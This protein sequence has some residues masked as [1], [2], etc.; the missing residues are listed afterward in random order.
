MKVA[1]VQMRGISWPW[2][3]PSHIMENSIQISI[4]GGSM[5]QSGWNK[6]KR[7]RYHPFQGRHPPRIGIGREF[8]RNGGSVEEIYHRFVLDLF[9]RLAADNTSGTNQQGLTF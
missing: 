9:Q 3:S 7:T 1:K 4:T 5:G 8:I 6:D 2:Q